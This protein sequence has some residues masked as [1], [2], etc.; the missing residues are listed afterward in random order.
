M[1]AAR[2]LANHG[3]DVE[4]IRSQAAPCLSDHFMVLSDLVNCG[5]GTQADFD[6]LCR[7]YGWIAHAYDRMY[8]PDELGQPMDKHL[9]EHARKRP[10]AG[11]Y[12]DA[13]EADALGRRMQELVQQG[14]FKKAGKLM[15]RLQG[16]HQASANLPKDAWVQGI[17][18]LEQLAD[19]AY[20]TMI[21]IH[22]HPLRWTSK[23]ESH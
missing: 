7:K 6:A 12:H 15:Q 16:L 22:K 18:Y 10:Y 23:P 9:L 11:T 14:Q 17:G 2:S 13:A 1:S 5:V 3:A 8:D 19:H 20:P 4:W 21:W